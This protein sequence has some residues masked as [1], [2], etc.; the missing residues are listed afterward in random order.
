VT[1]SRV[2]RHAGLILVIALA[3]ASTCIPSTSGAQ[4]AHRATGLLVALGDS[5][6]SGEGNPPFVASRGKC[7]QSISSSWPHLAAQQLGLQF[8][9][10]AC[11]GAGIWSLTGAWSARHVPAQV[12]ELQRLKPS[13]VTLTIGGNSIIEGKAHTKYSQDWGFSD[14]LTDC[15]LH[16][17]VTDGTLNTAK[18]ELTSGPNPP[19]GPNG[20][21]ALQTRLIA[22]YRAVA[23]AAPSAQIYIAGYPTLVPPMSQV[24]Y[25]CGWLGRDE[26]SALLDFGTWLDGL[27]E[28]SV[29]ALG[30]TYWSR[31]HYVDLGS[32]LFGHELCTQATWIHPI[33]AASGAGASVGLEANPGHPTGQGQQSMA[34]RFAADE[35]VFARGGPF[36][37]VCGDSP[38]VAPSEMSWCSSGCSSVYTNIR[39]TTWSSSRA[40]GT[41]TEWNNDG[42]P[43]CGSG[44]W[45]QVANKAI[46]LSL[47]RHITYCDGVQRRTLTMYTESS[48]WLSNT[49]PFNLIN[50]LTI[51]DDLNSPGVGEKSCGVIANIS[52][53]TY[54]N[55]STEYVHGTTC[56]AGLQTLTHSVSNPNPLPGWSCT[57]GAGYFVWAAC[58][59]SA[60]VAASTEVSTDV[61]HVRLIRLAN[62]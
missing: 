27:I 18:S 29:D 54:L 60:D 3:F 57:S 39:W 58:G 1:R 45:T 44:T 15:Y 22:A 17:C 50:C 62:L 51:A 49:L 2:S 7:D 48:I 11:S 52:N 4:S 56:A 14:I 41:A 9:N 28:S 33:T 5:Y 6:S 61:A 25:R 26:Q 19:A 24:P 8:V 32:T 42:I 59:A 36:V 16:H 40:V 12:A 55:G 34:S 23:S 21:P 37:S 53:L 47:A 43:D 20:T 10:L 31:V 35:S 13:V 38:K 30:P 46:S